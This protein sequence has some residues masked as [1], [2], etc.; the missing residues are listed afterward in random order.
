MANP[1]RSQHSHAARLLAVIVLA[2]TFGFAQEATTAVSSDED[3]VVTLSP[4]E[5]KASGERDGYVTTTTLAGNRLNTQLKDL[6]T[7]ISVYNEQFLK[8]IGAIDNQS[9]LKYTLGTEIGGVNGN[10]SGSGGGTAPDKDS[11]YLNP[12]STNRVRGLISADN[13]RD[14]F[15]SAIPW[16]GYNIEAVDLQ[17]GPNAIL[18]G[19]GSPG[20]VINTRTKQ[21]NY[22]NA[23]E[24]TVRVDEYGSVRGTLDFNRVLLKDELALRVA[25]VDSSAKFQQQ[26]AFEQF[27]REFL[28]VRY[29][30]KFLKKGGARTIFKA[31]G[32]IGH[33]NSNRPRNMPPGDRITPWFTALN[34]RLY[35]PAWMN[36]NNLDI[37]GRGD[38][39]QTGVNNQPNPNYQ[40]WVGTNFGN[41]YYAGT[42][43]LYLPGSTTPALSLTL[44]PNQ[45]LGVNSLGERDGTISGLAPSQPHGIR[46]YRDWA[47]ATKQP[48][49]TLIKDKF[50]TNPN[51]FDF[52]NKL[53][54][55][56]IKREWADFDTFD[57]SLSQ[58]FFGDTMGFDVGYHHESYT[59]GNYA[60]LV[61]DGGSIFIDFNTVWSDGTND[62]ASGWYTDGTKN[63]GAGRAFLQLGNGRSESTQTRESVRATAFVSHDFDSGKRTNWVTRIL[64]TQTL[65]GMASQDTYH[66]FS[67]SWVNSAFTG[68]YYTHPMFKS[69]KDANGRFWA[70]FVPLRT[71]YLS[72]SLV[73]KSLGQN[74]GINSPGSDPEIGDTMTIRY[75]D[76]TWNATGVNP[77]DPWYNQVTAGSAAGPALQTQSENP[78]NYVG[79]VNKPVTLMRATNGAN[80]NLL[81]TSRSWD[82][83]RNKAYAFVWQGKF[84]DSS[85]V[86]TA[87]IRQDEVSQILTRWDN[88]NSADRASGDPTLVTPTVSTLGP[89]KRT[90]KSWGAVAHLNHLPW[91]SR[92]AK[93]LPIEI[94]ATFNRSANF[95][96]G[97]VFRDYFGQELPLPEGKTKDMGVIL[98]TKNGKYSV[99]VNKFESTVANN[100]SSF[101]QF[102]N[103]G[104]NVGIYAQAW[105]QF[106]Y[107]YETRSNPGSTRHGS[108]IVSDLPVPTTTNPNTRWTF[109]YQ[110]IN[111]Q[112]I[113]QAE[114]QEVAVINAWD[115]WLAEMSPLPQTMGKAWGFDWQN[116]LTESGLGDFRLTSDLVSKGYEIELNAQVTDSWRLTVNASRIESTLS[117]IGQTLAPGGKMTVIDYLLDFDRRINDTVMGDLRIWGGSS[118]ATARENWAGFADGDLKARLAEQGTVVP[119]NR[120][121]HINLISN[122]DFREGRLKGWSLGGA[123]RYQSAAT[124]GYTPVQNPTYISYDLSKPFKDDAQLDFDVWVGYQRRLLRDKVDW[125]VQLNIANVGVGNELVPVTVQPD[126]TPAAYRIRPSQQVFLTNTFRF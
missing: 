31:S 101:I 17:R 113:E 120:L 87:G 89:L 49:S 4:F 11:A 104:N 6:G 39:V 92:W 18:F 95:Q 84:W 65:T 24:I 19:Q 12:Q 53:I 14:L 62:A 99:K 123:A 73:G 97:Q 8:D 28:A 96:T 107:N 114:A 61:G 43:F 83:R 7:S 81:T 15:L 34:Q 69:T 47:I 63:P 125:R 116:D 44:L 37:P 68:A 103:Y 86:G 36:D 80:R 121:W 88:Q 1:R 71:V 90:S 45:Y 51:T 40:P 13:T 122:Y 52:Y 2:P 111:G 50:I 48:F 5:V 21:A 56:D 102:W 35:N 78:A 25:A 32:E 9:L 118:S 119:E 41:N 77:A 70:D 74:L 22:R 26:P 16:D 3:E 117:N 23:H 58:T 82:D 126:G 29:E 46:G 105:S 72:D 79:W 115:Q 30:P 67:S 59:S 98:A 94:S 33:S 27:N 66:N 108:G 20:G 91:L 60:P 100:P 93:N 76:P 10:F 106:K 112:T 42:E 109:D 55:G 85:V 57:V 75:F 54:D 110:P 64:G 124:L 38:A